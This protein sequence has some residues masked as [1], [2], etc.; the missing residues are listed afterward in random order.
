MAKKVIKLTESKLVDL[1]SQIMLENRRHAYGHEGINGLYNDLSNDDDV[2]LSN[3]TGELRGD[4]VTKKEYLQNM[5]RDAIRR[6]DWGIVN[7]AI[8]YIS[9]KM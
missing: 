2:H 8:S 3:N 5:L 7:N 6:K 4:I 9:V 1:I